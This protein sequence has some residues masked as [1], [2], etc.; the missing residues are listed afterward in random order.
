MATLYRGNTTVSAAEFP[1]PQLSE[2]EP[3][4]IAGALVICGGG[5]LPPAAIE[6]FIELAGGEEAKLVVIPT[7]SERADQAEASVWTSA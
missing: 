6:Q 1:V 4:G 3:A 7:A 2:I 5:E